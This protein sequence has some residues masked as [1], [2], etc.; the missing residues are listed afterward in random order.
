M[1]LI[2][3]IIVS[4]FQCLK[5]VI[6]VIQIVQLYFVNSKL[7]GHALLCRFGEEGEFWVNTPIPQVKMELRSVSKSLFTDSKIVSK[8]SAI[9]YTENKMQLASMVR[10]SDKS[11]KLE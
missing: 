10:M 6:L 3:S 2:E 5:K 9:G 4:K 8:V 7:S 11:Y 1:T